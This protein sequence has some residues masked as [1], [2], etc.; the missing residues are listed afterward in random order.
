MSETLSVYV[1]PFAAAVLSYVLCVYVVSKRRL[2]IELDKNRF[3]KAILAHLQ[4]KKKEKDLSL[5]LI[6]IAM[7]LFCQEL[8]ILVTESVI[9]H[10]ANLYLI[11]ESPVSP[12]MYAVFA[13]A[14][15][16][17]FVCLI[18]GWCKGASRAFKIMLFV[19]PAFLICE[20]LLFN[21][22][23]FSAD[24]KYQNV[25]IYLSAYE[26]GE[27]LT[28]PIY[29]AEGIVLE[30]DAS[31]VFYDFPDYTRAVNISFDR[32]EV[33]NPLGLFVQLDMKDDN[34]SAAF[35]V[36]DVKAVSGY[37]DVNL[38]IRPY[39]ELKQ[40]ELHVTGVTDTVT[41][42]SI[43]A[44]NTNPY[45][46][47]ALRYAVAVVLVAA[48]VFVLE[49]K[50]Y[51][52]YFD[53][54][55]RSHLIA[56]GLVCLLTVCSTFLLYKTDE[57]ELIDYPFY[58]NTQVEDIYAL[59]FD[60]MK[61]GL[62]YLDLPSEESLEGLD[63][64]YDFTERTVAGSHYRW[65]YAYRDGHYYCYFGAT[66]VLLFYYPLEFFTGCVPS[67]NLALSLSGTLAALGIV[68]A[69]VAAARKYAPRKKLLPYL[70]SIPV[71]CVSSTMFYSLMYPMKYYLPVLCALAG[72]G[73]AIFFGLTAVSEKKEWKGFVFFVL[74]GISLA[75]CAG[76][77]PVTAMGA[78]V[79]LPAFFGVLANKKFTARDKILKA[80]AFALPVIIGIALI[81]SY[82]NF[83]FG[84][85]F[86]FG[87]NYQLTIS[88]INSLN[89]D[90]TLL[91]AALFYF[92]FQPYG[93]AAT[94]PFFQ[95]I[96]YP[97][98]NYEIYRNI[99]LNVGV[100][101]LPFFLSGLLLVW[102][103]LLRRRKGIKARAAATEYNAYVLITIVIMIII[104]W[105][106]FCRGGTA[107]R[108]TSDFALILA[109][110]SAI[111][112]LRRLALPAGRK[113]LY[114]IIIAA[115]VVTPVLILMSY[116]Q[117]YNSNLQYIYPELCERAEDFF[118]FWR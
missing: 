31:I 50:L 26:T 19:T 17:C 59:K 92:F 56:L 91:P 38:F 25:D 77:R 90:I 58:Y 14:F 110:M 62:P 63:N 45:Q 114:G 9:R 21:L 18:L 74:S 67:Y 11:T 12:V 103:T 24:Q 55:K 13:F 49:L 107:V 54:R 104:A 20:T 41:V 39:G 46:T 36:A 71:V 113:T 48:I 5:L 15:D 109:M 98:N 118:L 40:T 35:A 99:E 33:K 105:F 47:N 27:D 85:P 16:A 53:S 95:M 116:L 96:A 80:A 78:A 32:E 100:F 117:T 30:G 43:T 88:N 2:V 65:D 94:F 29:T 112:L 97:I 87:E 8:L 37:R 10:Y 66:P 60:A 4:G 72:L 106:D 52:V 75:F 7:V 1:W 101:N 79:L 28:D 6:L 68:L 89:V 44:F 86:D 76:A 108:Y 23:S 84:N 83:R 34:T 22:G 70:L 93:M 61:K 102:G 111:V 69:Y 81:L 51:K 42:T 73:F 115:M 57:F 64:I 3:C 82:N